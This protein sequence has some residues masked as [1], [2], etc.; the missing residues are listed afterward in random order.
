MRKQFKHVVYRVLQRI[1][2]SSENAKTAI[3]ISN[4]SDSYNRSAINH[5]KHL[6]QPS[7]SESQKKAITD[8]WKG[9]GIRIRDFSQFQWYYGKTGIEDPR[10]IPQDVWK[11]VI[12]PYYNR[13]EYETVFKNKNLFDIFLPNCS[14]PKTIVKKVGDIFY[15][16]SGINIDEQQAVQLI[17]AFPEVILKNATDT[18]QGKNVAKYAVSSVE[19]ALKVLTQWKDKH[20]FLV[21]EVIQQHPFFSQFNESSVNIIRFNSLFLNGKVYVHTP[22]LRFGLPGHVT[23]CAHINGEEIVRMVG[24]H[25]DGE[26]RNRAIHLNGDEESILGSVESPITKVPAFDKIL[27]LI[28]KNARQ[29]PYFKIIGW[30]I[31]VDKDNNPIVVEF[32]IHM[33]S[34]Y[35][36]QI[37]NGPMWGD[38][39]SLLLSFLENEENRRLYIPSFYRLK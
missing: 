19:D 23:D 33:P 10:F 37:T 3:W 1:E 24:I 25:D 36:S 7:L 4:V 15:D 17:A 2:K 30:D 20:D 32:N 31:T 11:N 14:F 8:Y 6:E 16:K 5:L 12:L 13:K 27:E 39:T 26:I 22:V 29:M 28:D 9:Y 34:S 21:Q 38:D 18:G 35:G